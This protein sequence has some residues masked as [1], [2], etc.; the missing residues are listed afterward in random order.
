[1]LS[2][3]LLV[4]T[5]ASPAHAADDDPRA[6]RDHFSLALGPLLRTDRGRPA[7]LQSGLAIEG[8][9]PLAWRFNL[10]LD[11]MT[12]HTPR[13]DLRIEGPKAALMAVYHQPIDI[14]AVDFALGPGA[15]FGKSSWWERAYPG[16]WPGWRAAVG[17]TYRPHEWVGARLDV[18]LDQHFG[19]YP[20]VN[21]TS[22]GW[23]LRL[24]LIGWVP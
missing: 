10:R 20:L 24:M 5:L 3:T 19:T 21:G 17:G 6:G 8:E 2:S 14:F 18:G 1:M 15:W 9:V 11:Y 16:P 7:R 4:L 23:D 13:D 12:G 22:T